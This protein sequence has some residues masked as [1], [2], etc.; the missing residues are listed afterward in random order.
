MDICNKRLRSVNFGRYT[1]STMVKENG[2]MMEK[3]KRIK[4]IENE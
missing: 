3:L 4:V 2:V 1:I